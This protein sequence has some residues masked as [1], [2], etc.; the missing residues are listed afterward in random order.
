MT[1]F[2]LKL[3]AAEDQLT[4]TCWGELLEGSQGQRVTVNTPMGDDWLQSVSFNLGEVEAKAER[5]GSEIE[6]V[7]STNALRDRFRAWLLEANERAERG[8]RTMRG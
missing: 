6:I 7:F 1:K 5:N 3:L 4:V 2:N 8:F